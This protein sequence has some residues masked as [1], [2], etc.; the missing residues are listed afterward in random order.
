MP[1]AA[2]PDYLGTEFSSASPGMRFGMYLKLWGDFKREVSGENK[3][4][5]LDDVRKLTGNDKNTMSSL[6]AR[7]KQMFDAS[8]SGETNLRLDAYATAPF[9]TGL[10]NEHPLENGFAFFN[11]YGLPYLPGSG[12]KGVI[13]QAVRELISGEW[14]ES[15]GWNTEA[16]DILLGRDSVNG[17][18]N[19]L[20]GA[21]IFW[22]VIPQIQENSLSVEIMTPHQSQYYQQKREEKSGSSMSP[23]D[24]GQPVPIQFLTLPP[25]TLFNFHVQCDL[26]HLKNH[27]PELLQKWKLMTEGAF[28][29]AYQWLGFGAKTAVGYGAMES[30]KLRHDKVER[31]KVAEAAEKEEARQR[32]KEQTQSNAVKWEGARI[33]YDR[34]N[35]SLSAEKD[36]KTAR[37]LSPKGEE[38]YKSLSPELQKKLERNE[39]VKVDAKVSGS[40][41]LEI[42]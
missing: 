3:A 6:I 20:R 34:R 10:G 12:I 22:D 17:D 13:R 35:G 11:P 5:A 41:L 4:S 1:K 42:F 8:V 25:R 26:G 7:Q 39:F 32:K 37:A 31:A 14:G 24:S 9:T 19:H 28:E 38:L 15:L 16:M 29:L 18:T 36:Q 40:E 2:V 30:E 21:L 23:H 33:K 27:A